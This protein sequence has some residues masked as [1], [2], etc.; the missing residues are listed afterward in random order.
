MKKAETRFQDIDFAMTGWRLIIEHY[1][2]LKD[3]IL[4]LLTEAAGKDAVDEWTLRAFSRDYER[5]RQE[6]RRRA[7]KP[8]PPIKLDRE[9]CIR[10]LSGL[11]D[12]GNDSDK[13]FLMNFA[14]DL[15]KMRL[16]K[17]K[18]EAKE[19]SESR[20]DASNG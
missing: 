2:T 11:W 5:A 9:K 10:I 8:K 4:D 7:R 12:S 16:E 18:L 20:K 17:R 1:P 14:V 6:R 13:D 19:A 3:P 15:E